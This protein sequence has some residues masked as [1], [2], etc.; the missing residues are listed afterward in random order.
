MNIICPSI[1][2]ADFA[3]LGDQIAEVDNAGAKYLHIDIMDGVFVPSISMGMPV[4]KSI[5][6][7][8][9]LV[10]DVHLMIVDPIR[11]IKEIADCGADTITFHYEAA[12][13]PKAAIDEI[14]SCGK[15]AGIAIKPAT[16][17][18]EIVPYLDDVEM[19]LIM[20]VEPGFGGQKLIPSSFDKIR[21]VRKIITDRNLNVDVEVDGGVYTNNVKEIL[22][23]GANV[24]VSGSGVF[25]GNPSENVAEFRR[26]LG[27]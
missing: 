4:I 16:P 22:D 20:T 2:S 9:D 13:D 5:R 3:R 19:V 17:V 10:F 24:I 12:E 25:K 23:A 1:L 11:Y 6:R 7:V 18:S 14:H 15:K 27:V 8:T 21:E 26:I